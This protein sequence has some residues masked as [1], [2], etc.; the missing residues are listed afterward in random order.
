MVTS[1][2]SASI[3][4]D[5]SCFLKRFARTPDFRPTSLLSAWARNFRCGSPRASKSG[6]RGAREKVQ[7]HRR[8]FGAGRRLVTGDEAAREEHGNDGAARHPDGR[9]C[10]A[11]GRR[12]TFPCCFPKMLAA[13]APQDGETYI[14]GTFGAGGYTDAIL[15]AAPGA[16]VLAIDRDR[17]AIAAGAALVA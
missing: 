7:D 11:E 5:A 2:S 4:T 12:A 13:L 15:T 10:S 8:L 17:Q 16:R 3:R 14:D 1:T 6:A 9:G